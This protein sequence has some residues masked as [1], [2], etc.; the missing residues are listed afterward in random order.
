M[1]TLEGE[2]ARR[3]AIQFCVQT[4]ITQTDTYKKLKYKGDYSSVSRSLVFE[5]HSRF[6]DGWADSA[7]LG[8]KPSMNV[9]KVIRTYLTTTGVRQLE[10][11]RFVH[12]QASYSSSIDSG[13][14]D[15]MFQKWVKRRRKYIAHNK[16]YAKIRN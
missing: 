4:G 3:S 2:K 14:L 16:K 5:W 12:E 10:K 1:A 6:S 7:Q 8:R 15:D 13:W 9:V 11:W